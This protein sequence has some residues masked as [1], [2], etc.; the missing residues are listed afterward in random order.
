MDELNLKNKAAYKDSFKSSLLYS[1]VQ[2]FQILI[3]LIRSKFIAMIL[4][5]SGMG[6]T[7]L[8]R[9]TTDLISTTTNL[10][11]KTSVVKSI[12]SA[13]SNGDLEKI[14]QTIA[15]MRIL[16]L[17]TGLIGLLI[18]A[19]LLLYGALIHLELMIIFGLS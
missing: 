10:G 1:G 9:S 8:L 11:L 18:C 4:G 13:R 16:V 19:I 17:L 14:S 15:V 7:S 2:V 3:S 12:A 5:P 6:I